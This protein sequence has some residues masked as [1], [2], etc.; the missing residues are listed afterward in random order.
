V[1][2]ADLMDRLEMSSLV[3]LFMLYS[4]GL[5]EL[6]AEPDF[7]STTADEASGVV[8]LLAWL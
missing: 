7:E 8:A 3:A 2:C 5:V 1:D 4:L 6:I